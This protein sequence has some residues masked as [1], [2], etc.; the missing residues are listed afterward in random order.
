MNIKDLDILKKIY[1]KIYSFLDQ[2]S[3]L[4]FD[5]QVI[6]IENII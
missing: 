3:D 4:P 1:K 5:Q 2:M 6:I